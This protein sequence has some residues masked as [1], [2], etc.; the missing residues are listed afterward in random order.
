MNTEKLVAIKLIRHEY[1]KK[2]QKNVSMIE[3]EIIVQSGLRH[4]N[5]T[6][7]I[8]YGSDGVVEKASGR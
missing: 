5:I 1:M 7:L 8:A 2:D 6:G 3:T 4:P